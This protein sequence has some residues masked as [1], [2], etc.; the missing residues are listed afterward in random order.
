MLNYLREVLG[1]ESI[2]GC[3][4]ARPYC[5]SAELGFLLPKTL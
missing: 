2:R 1:N 3:A 5:D 4:D